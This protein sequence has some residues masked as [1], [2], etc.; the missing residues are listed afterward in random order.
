MRFS[1]PLIDGTWVR[2][3]QRFLVD[4]QLSDGTLTTAHC[5]NTGSMIGINHPGSRVM[6][7][8]SSNPERKLPTASNGG[9]IGLTS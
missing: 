7:L 4:V 8:D 6:L 1:T 5:P 3:Y 2:R 9:W